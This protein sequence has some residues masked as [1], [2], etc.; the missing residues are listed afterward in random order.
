M[1]LLTGLT[2]VLLSVS[3]PLQAQNTSMESLTI[4]DGLSQGMIYDILQTKDGFLWIATKDGLNR[5][6]GYHFE[7]YINDPFNPYSIAG[8]EIT[9]L[10]EDSRGNIWVALMGRGCDVLEKKSGRFLHLSAFPEIPGKLSVYSFEES[11]DSTIWLGTDNGLLKLRWKNNKIP[12]VGNPELPTSASIEMASRGF[13]PGKEMVNSIIANADGSL[14]ISI[15]N[16]GIYHFD[17]DHG[18]FTFLEEAEGSQ[19]GNLLGESAPGRVWFLHVNDYKRLMVFESGKVTKIDNWENFPY[20]AASMHNDNHGNLLWSTR[21]GKETF[22]Y[23]MPESKAFTADSIRKPELIAHLHMQCASMELDLGGNLWVGT[24]GYGLRKIKLSR[25]PF[26]HFLKGYSVR[27]ILSTDD[28]YMWVGGSSA[29]WQLNESANLLNPIPRLPLDVFQFYQTKHGG[30][31]VIAIDFKHYYLKDAHDALPAPRHVDFPT[32]EYS[33]ITEDAS[34]NIWIGGWDAKL[35]RFQPSTGQI[36]YLDLSAHFGKGS[37]VYALHIDAMQNLWMGTTN[38][39]AQIHLPDLVKQEGTDNFQISKPII[40]QTD[41]H[42]PL[43]L[44]YNFVTSFCDDPHQP[45][46][47]LWVS[48]KGGGVSLLDK[49]TNTFRHFTN[50]NSG[51]PNDVVYGIL[52]DDDGNLWMSTNRGLSRMTCLPSFYES[53]TSSSAVEETNKGIIFQN[54]RESDGLQSDEFNTSAFYRHPD[55]RLFF[56]GVNGLTAFY[57]SDIKD[58]QSNAPVRITG[59]KINNLAVDYFK[60]K[61]PLTR[62]INQT[63]QI[64]LTH[65]QNLVTLDFA[66]MDFVTPQENRFRYRLHGVDPDWVDAGIGHTANYAQLRPGSYL[67]EVQGNIGYGEWS[68]PATL[69]I[70]VCPPWWAS[71][72]AYTL[73]GVILIVSLYRI[74]Y[75]F[76]KRLQLQHQVKLNFEEANR[77]KE[78]D[79]FK[80]QLFTNLTHEFRTPLTVIL[81][82]AKQLSVGSRQSSVSSNQ[83]SVNSNQSAVISRQSAV[84]EDEKMVS[85]LKLIESN[86][87]NLLHLIN[88]LLDLSKLENKSFQLNLK[89]GDI[90]PY[91][92]YVT[93]SFQSYANGNNLSLRFFTTIEKLVMDFDPE[94][95]KQVMTNLVSNALKFTPSGGDIMV[96]LSNTQGNLIIEVKD[97]GIGIAS[98]DI[99]HI[100]D[101]FFQVDSSSTRSSQG[102]GIGLA[103]AQE[104]LK[105]MGGSISV[106]SEFNKGT[107]FV[108]HLPI[109]NDAILL[110]NNGA[111]MDTTDLVSIPGMRMKEMKED[112]SSFIDGSSSGSSMPQ[113]L[114]I[115]DNPDVVLYLKSCLEDTYQIGVAYNGKIGIEKAL[116]HIPDFIISDVMMP[117]KDGYQVCDTLKNDERTS[118]IPIIL[119]TAKADAA[120]RI[121]GLRRGADA[122]LAK[123]F[124]VEELLVQISVLLD[125]RHRMANHFSKTLQVGQELPFEDIS[126]PEEIHVEDA[127]VKK[128][129]AIIETHYADEGFSLPELCLQIGMSRSQ[130]FRKMKAVANVSP[131]DL[132]RSYRLNKAKALL[133]NGDVTVAEVTYQVGFKDPSYFSKIFQDEFG[134]QPSRAIK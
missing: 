73:Y 44:R 103:H 37:T 21:V 19:P 5:Y 23:S 126:L 4:A 120:S 3:C 118:H 34:G 55:G 98:H 11:T 20:A 72:W 2:I 132:I 41:P 67:F 113:L 89:Q 94:Q 105:I 131:S 111:I 129:K 71:W 56:G 39:M 26:Q 12:S 46:R 116:E 75:L 92:R 79:T 64:T 29:P 61:S 14:L 101:R 30:A 90:V 13:Q 52:P 122:Y 57:P 24:S 123:P 84:T 54:F 109:T 125:N 115:E 59:L 133:E 114:I 93:E 80:S 95:I 58:R 119:L 48:T 42:N 63:E 27:R 85:G 112:V 70:T 106:E 50:Q 65:K 47:F 127:F 87:K 15:N 128:V 100:F 96:K 108:V 35:M 51:L 45:E 36:T 77:L 17:P 69:R 86:G 117:E 121:A 68:A 43:S 10:F 99:V 7:V 124:D 49:T 16:D 1:K 130:L 40:Y 107:R 18:E 60:V 9:T 66:L 25:Q 102:T 62:P 78:L 83:S 81:G 104:L 91:L 8:N 22:I 6:D 88:Q 74:I 28:I 134:I 33:P 110:K 31:Y 97:T 38:G 76:K 32:H 53:A 82:M